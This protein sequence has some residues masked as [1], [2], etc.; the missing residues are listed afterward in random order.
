MK[1][2]AAWIMD[3]IVGD[4]SSDWELAMR[5]E[6]DELENGHFSWASGCLFVRSMNLAKREY[7]FIGAIILLPMLS[8]IIAMF[9]TT[10][11]FFLVLKNLDFP[12]VIM[13]LP[14]IA[15]QLPFGVLLG[16]VRPR[17]VPLI[18]GMLGFVSQQL[19]PQF[20]LWTL[21]DAPFNFWWGP[22]VTIYNMTPIM[23]YACSL[24]MWVGGAYLG[25]WLGRRRLVR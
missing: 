23:G 9:V 15:L 18:I 2:L 6:Y 13:S 16:M 14:M 21:L 24:T 12:H 25:A 17:R 1:W 7:Q 20:L 10:G 5:R 3:R 4:G 11:L 22:N 8:L 19:F